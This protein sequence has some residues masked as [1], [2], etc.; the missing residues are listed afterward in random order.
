MATYRPTI[1]PRLDSVK[2]LSVHAGDAR[3]LPR[4]VRLWDRGRRAGDTRP[5]KPTRVLAVAGSLAAVAIVLVTRRWRGRPVPGRRDRAGATIEEVAHAPVVAAHAVATEI[6]PEVYLLG[7]WGRTQTN[8]YLVSDG[9]SWILVDAGWKGDG[10]RIQAAAR[11]LLGPERAPSAILLT[12][13]HPDHDGSAR[14]LAEAWR[15]PVYTHP[16]ELPLAT[17][18]FAAMARHAGPLDR[19]LI[20]PGMRAIGGRRREAMLARSS[21]AGI[22]GQL[23]P[24]GTIPGVDGWRWIHTPGHTPG[25]VAYVRDRDRVVLSGD[26]IVTLEVNAL[27]GLLVQR[28]GLSGPPWYTTWDRRAAIAS[29]AGIAALEPSVLA[30]GHGLPLAAPG[31]AAAV[32]R[33]ARRTMKLWGN[34]G[35]AANVAQRKGMMTARCHGSGD[36]DRSGPLAS[37][38]P[39]A[40]PGTGVHARGPGRDPSALDRRTFPGGSGGPATGEGGASARPSSLAGGGTGPGSAAGDTDHRGHHDPDPERCGRRRR[41]QQGEEGDVGESRDRA[42]RHR[43]GVGQQ[44]QI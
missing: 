3:A 14:E 25:H 27:A 16:A 13:A 32:H 43:R 38:I 24:G 22:V 19:W 33:F 31:T 23:G 40:D 4:A 29:I 41:D 20:L 39:L 34:C 10:P 17:G 7:P 12:H 8:A 6:A 5:V 44:C 2:R 35:C 18:D 37:T 42:A 1:G 30:G 28:Q 9:A 11:S 36:L 26:A 15:C 21:L